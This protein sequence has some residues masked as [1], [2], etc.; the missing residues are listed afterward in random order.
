MA[1]SWYDDFED[2]WVNQIYH[3]T[4]NYKTP[5]LLQPNKQD[6]NTLA[7]VINIDMITYLNS[8]RILQFYAEIDNYKSITNFFN[9]NVFKCLFF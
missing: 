7:N 5:L 9:I 2:D 3:K 4:D 8:Q 1:D 6:K